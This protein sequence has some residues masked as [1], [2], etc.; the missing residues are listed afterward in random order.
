M[1]PCSLHHL[2]N[3]TAVS[4]ISLLRPERPVK[5]LSVTV[6][7]WMSVSVTPLSDAPFA[8]PGLQTL[9]MSPN[10][11]L[12]NDVSLELPELTVGGELE[13]CESAVPPPLREH[14]AKTSPSTTAIPTPR[15]RFM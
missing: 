4:Y 3:A 9:A 12:A 13:L 15:K 10:P 6:A 7:I 8:S 11:P 14:E 2:E 5:P 1:P